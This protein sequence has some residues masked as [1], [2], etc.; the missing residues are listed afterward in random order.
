MLDKQINKLFNDFFYKSILD[1]KYLG[2]VKT[3]EGSDIDGE[4]KKQTFKS[5]N[6]LTEI[7]NYRYNSFTDLINLR[8]ELKNAIDKQDFE[9]AIVLR[10]KIN[11]LEKERNSIVKN[12]EEL[13]K[14]IKSENYD[15][16]IEI[17]NKLKENK[18]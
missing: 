15:L 18:K 4:W 9:G 6:G 5:K 13:E 16:A 3:E 10:D 7:V 17:L 14:A 1:P 8:S 12:K 2:E 11:N